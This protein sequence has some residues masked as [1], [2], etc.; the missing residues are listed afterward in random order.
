MWRLFFDERGQPHPSPT[1]PASDDLTRLLHRTIKKVT[2]DT[3][4]MNFNTAIAAMMT[5]VNEGDQGPGAPACHSEPFV[6]LL[7]P[8][9]RRH[10]A[11]EL[12]EALGSSGDARPLRAVAGLRRGAHSG[13]DDRPAGAGG[14]AR[15]APRWITRGRR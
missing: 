10:I 9:T 13:A 4:S 12:W 8:F 14:T 15:C 5:F 7:A 3:E 6:L 11:E 1:D 2:E